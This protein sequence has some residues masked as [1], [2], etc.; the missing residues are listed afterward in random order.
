MDGTS[1]RPHYFPGTWTKATPSICWSRNRGKQ[2][3]SHFHNYLISSFRKAKSTDGQQ[4]QH[5]WVRHLSWE[6]SLQK[7]GKT[8]KSEVSVLRPSSHLP[9]PHIPLFKSHRELQEMQHLPLPASFS[10]HDVDH[11]W[12]SQSRHEK[13]W[14]WALSQGWVHLQR[15]WIIFTR[16]GEKK[17]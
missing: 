6:S 9:W 7:L 8:Q 15:F 5:G 3:S 11:D 13:V 16:Q 1:G 17:I 4:G 2:F 12:K 10:Q 14:L